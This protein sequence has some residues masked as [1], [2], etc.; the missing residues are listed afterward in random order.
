[1]MAL[2]REVVTILR[3]AYHPEGFNIGMNIGACAGAGVRDHIHLH[4]VPRWCG[5]TNFMT[6]TGETRVLPEDLESGF[7]RLKP[8]FERL[9]SG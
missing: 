3:E 2:S 7:R 4:V 5:D 6:S 9:A 1:M 8:L